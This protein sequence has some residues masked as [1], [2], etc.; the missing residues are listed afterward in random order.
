MLQA[1]QGG[2]RRWACILL[3]ACLFAAAVLGIGGTSVQVSAKTAAEYEK[4]IQALE[5]KQKDLNKKL[6]DT[7]NKIKSEQE[8]QKLLE[9]Q[10]GVVEEQ[11]RLYQDKI[12]L[13]NENIEKLEADIA[14]K[15]QEIDT[16]EE[17][18]AQRVRAMYISN[19][20]N[21]T[22]NS[23]LTAKSFAQ[24]L[25]NAEILKRISQSDQDLIHELMQQHETLDLARTDLVDEQTALQK[26]QAELDE[27]SNNLDSLYQKSNS[28]EAAL[29]KAEK[30]YYLQL[31]KNAK[32]IKQQEAELAV[33]IANAGN[34]GVAPGKLLWPVPA[35]SRITSPFGWRWIF[36]KK[37][38]H[39][40]L[41]IAAPKGTPIVAAAD[42]TVLTVK[43]NTYGYG[44]YVV[45]NHGGGVSTLYAHCSR[46]DVREGQKVK[47]GQ[48]IAGVGTTGNSTGNHLHFEVRINGVQ[49]DPQGYVSPP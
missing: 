48:T 13:V 46:I 2:A 17:F 7:T 32:A 24:F 12:N 44:W 49:K 40:G 45:V 15:L 4:E 22:L 23:L 36:G 21:S 47:M 3:S 20:S 5:N 9:E 16:N 30:D 34:G 29:K 14:L 37:E 6:S 25:N 27:K 19:T 35:S 31:E 38:F 28:Q 43:K 1:V 41:D 26:T 39:K 42:G 33:L 18:F 8:K 10:I 11:L